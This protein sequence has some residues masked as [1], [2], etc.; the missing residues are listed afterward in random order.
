MPWGR[1][2]TLVVVALGVTWILDGLEVTMA[3]AVAG[4]LKDS[5]SLALSDAEIGFASSAYLAGAVVGALFFGWLTDRLGRKKLF[6]ITLAPYLAAT[7]ATAFSWDFLSFVMFRFL[8]GAG[9]GGEYAAVNS[10][11]QELI[12]A[13]VRGCTDLVINGS[14]WIGAAVGA[15]GSLALLDP[16]LVNPALGWRFCFFIGAA[17]GLVILVMRMWIPESPR[18]LLIHGRREEADAIMASIESRFIVEG[19]ALVEGPFPTTTLRGR[20]VTSFADIGRTLF[21][22][23]PYRTL[24]GLCLMASQALLYNAVFFTYALI[25]TEFYGVPPED[26][27]W[28][29]LALVVSNFLGP[30]LLGHLFDTLGRKF[31]ISITYAISGLLLAIVSYMFERALVSATGQTA[32]W[33]LVFFFASTAASSAYLTV[34]ETFPLE[35]RA[36]AI[37]IF[38]AVGT[39]V[40]GVLSPWLFGTL[41]GTGSRLGVFSGYALASA[42]MIG[43]AFVESRWGVSAE[44]KP[45]E[46]VCTPLT[47]VDEQPPA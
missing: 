28:H 43:A 44:R 29:L 9:I 19:A 33:M 11:I 26:V 12:P 21:K 38:Y 45:L 30:V 16:T 35:M 47:F 27:G 18:W 6:L 10:T 4:V 22:S 34:G 7:A 14:F 37:A 46:E 23:Y 3:G 25:L 8:V 36:V 40:G 1:F 13:R 39:A 15:A 17:I 32:G 20:S 5:N 41:I 42:L 24:V 2:H 31:M